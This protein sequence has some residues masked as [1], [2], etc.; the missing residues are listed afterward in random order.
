MDKRYVDQAR[1]HADIRKQLTGNVS[2]FLLSLHDAE[3]DFDPIGLPRA[4]DL[5][6][7]RWKLLNLEKLKKH[8]PKKHAEQ[9]D[10]LEDL[11]H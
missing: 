1:L 8:N 7:V 6:A 2:V 9:R 4:L 3:P 5:P 10:A 11:L